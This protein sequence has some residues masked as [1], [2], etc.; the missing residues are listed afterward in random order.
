MRGRRVGLG[1]VGPRLLKRFP[2]AKESTFSEPGEPNA[3]GKD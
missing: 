3:F 1:D 2:V